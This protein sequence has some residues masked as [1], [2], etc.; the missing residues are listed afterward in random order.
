MRTSSNKLNETLKNQV[1]KTLAQVLTDLKNPD[2]AYQFL[3]DFFTEAEFESFAKRLA[4]AYWLKNGRSYVNIKNN[5]KVSSAT[6]ADISNTMRTKGFDLALKKLEAEEWAAQWAEK[7][8]K[9]INK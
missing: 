4:V 2:E 6:I 9:F 3:S 8:K 1:K 7:I 5:L